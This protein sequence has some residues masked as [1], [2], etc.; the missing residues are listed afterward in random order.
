MTTTTCSTVATPIAKIFAINDDLALRAL[1]GLTDQ[2]LWA[3][4]TQRNNA[5]LWVAGHVVQTRAFLLG[6]LGERFDTGWE[7]RFNRGATIGDASGY[8]SRGEIERV[9][10]DVSQ[11]LHAKFATLDDAQLAQQP[12]M[13]LPGA[14]TVA[15]QL[16]FFAFHDSYHVGQM[17]Y[18]R[19]ALGYPALAR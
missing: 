17:A 6:L 12:S 5:M 18:I 3:A 11:R 10:R 9:M 7:E 2:Q 1:D 8:P 16:A 19:K 14:K 15:D 13:D 4:P